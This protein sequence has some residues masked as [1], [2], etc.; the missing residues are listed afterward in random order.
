MF[1]LSLRLVHVRGR[2]A[3]SGLTVVGWLSER[4]SRGRVGRCAL[5]Q[6]GDRRHVRPE[7]AG[8]QMI[9]PQLT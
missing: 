6:E 5:D 9:G 3:P 2:S 4:V 8:Q 1:D 7:Q